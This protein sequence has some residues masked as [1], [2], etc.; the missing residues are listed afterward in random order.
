MAA[1]NVGLPIS[2]RERDRG[3]TFA[4]GDALRGVK[5]EELCEQVERLWRCFWE[6]LRNRRVSDGGRGAQAKVRTRGSA[7][8]RT[9]R[10]TTLVSS[11]SLQ[12]CRRAL[13][14]LVLRVIRVHHLDLLLRRGSENLDDLDELVDA[15]A[16][17]EED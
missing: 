5:R 10:R 1:K 12:E 6:E 3:R 15:R 4:S 8:G 14:E 7:T 11:R 2:W 16:P 13:R 17:S 9:E